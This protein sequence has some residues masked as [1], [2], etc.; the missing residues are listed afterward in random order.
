MVITNN[1]KSATKR[2]VK[3]IVASVVSDA[4]DKVLKGVDRMF[5]EQNKRVDKRFDKVETKLDKVE[6]GV[7][8]MTSSP[9]WK[10]GVSHK[11]G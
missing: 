5:S 6:T 11:G 7:V 3:E 4:V 1:N 2:E 9:H 10:C 8:F